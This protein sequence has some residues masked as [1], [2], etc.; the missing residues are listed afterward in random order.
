MPKVPPYIIY[1]IPVFFILIGVEFW[2]ARRQRKE[3]YR[4]N[5]A[6]AN[7]SCGVAQQVFS[8]LIRSVLFVGYLYLYKNHKLL[9]LGADQWWVWVLC[10]IGVD[11]FYYWF[12]RYAH[13]ISILWGGHIVHHQSEEYNLS[14][15]LRQ[16]AF[17]GLSSWVF[18]LPLAWIGFD[19]VVF[20]VVSQFQTLYQFWI[21]TR[22]IGKMWA[23]F[24]YVFNTPSHHRVHHGVNPKY[25][26]KNHGGTLIIWDR[27]FGTFQ[28]EEEEVVYGVTKPLASWNPVWANFDY[29][30][31]LGRLI[32]RCRNPLDM[33]KAIVKGPGWRP[34]YLGGPQKP[35][36]V[37]TKSFHKFD[38]PVPKGI[39][40]Y[41]L[42]QYVVVILCVSGFLLMSGKLREAYADD[43]LQRAVAIAGCA[44]LIYVSIVSMGNI[45]AGKPASRT[46]EMLRLTMMVGLAAFF[47]VG[48]SLFFPLMG[49]TVAYLAGSM[50]WFSRIQ[51][52]L[53]Q[54]NLKAN[55]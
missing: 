52:A 8:V 35:Q 11:F 28:V 22:L 25:I 3:V 19:P 26:D 5:D 18:Y 39:G 24:E 38:T 14:V 30:V 42:L 45:T 6:I 23:P 47:T 13:E 53:L 46:F 21:H 36:P 31:D 49:A 34:A 48:T 27:M 43:A 2:L 54:R 16:G 41:V 50:L 40:T 20:L 12:H 4:L 37:T 51:G 9:T 15:A 29:L 44:G 1:A 7:I 17:Q 10:F 33:L 32:L 55:G